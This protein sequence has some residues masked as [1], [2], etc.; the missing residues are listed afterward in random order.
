MKKTISAFLAVVF[1][2]ISVFALAIS[3]NADTVAKLGDIN[4]NGKI[5]ARDYLLLKRAYFGTYTLTCNIAVADINGNGK[6]DARDYLL[7]KR[8]YFGTFTFKNP[9]VII[10]GS[11]SGSGSGSDSGSGSGSS[12]KDEP[13]YEDDGYYNEV[14]KP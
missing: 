12:E 4:G 9:D 6:I 10:S 14:V 1:V 8:A 5:D 3:A 7:L 11:D 2:L 13:T